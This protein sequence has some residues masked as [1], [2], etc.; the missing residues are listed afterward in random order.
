M[1][2]QDEME[3]MAQEV[4]WENGLRLQVDRVFAPR[5]HAHTWCIKYTD[6]KRMSGQKTFTISV[7]W[8]VASTCVTVK[9]DLNQ[10]LQARVTP[11]L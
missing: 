6:P 7:N 3:R 8:Q 11:E 1:S 9:Q 10:Q 5:N 2:E 4:V